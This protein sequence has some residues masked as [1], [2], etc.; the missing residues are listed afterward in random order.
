M[1]IAYEQFVKKK[2]IPILRG[3][4]EYLSGF[5]FDLMETIRQSPW[6]TE[7]VID[8]LSNPDNKEDILSDFVRL[9]VYYKDLTVETIKDVAGFT[10]VDLLSDIGRYSLNK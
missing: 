5:G 10:W 8:Y 3:D 1:D 4:P 9:T 7:Q 2:M 6:L